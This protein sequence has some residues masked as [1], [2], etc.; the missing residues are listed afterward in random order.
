MSVAVMPALAAAND[1]LTPTRSSS[2]SAQQI[3]RSKSI[4]R[5]DRPLP[6]IPTEA[7]PSRR[8]P[9]AQDAASIPTVSA[10][11]AGKLRASPVSSRENIRKILREPRILY[12]LVERLPW[13]AFHALTSTC[14]EFRHLMDQTDLRDVILSQYVPGYRA[15]LGHAGSERDNTVDVDMSDLALLRESPLH[16]RAPQSKT[17]R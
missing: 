14:R 3:P 16:D 9:P 11:A 10:K 8:R 4:K 6:P 1:P 13:R 2:M 5:N 7:Q 12:R 15:C 17:L